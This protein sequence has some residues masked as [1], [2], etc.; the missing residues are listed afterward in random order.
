MEFLRL[1][2]LL[3]IC[4]AS[5]ILVN[6]Q[7]HSEMDP[8]AFVI[9][10]HYQNVKD[11]HSE[12][13]DQYLTTVNE[14]SIT[15]F[16][17]E[18]FDLLD[19]E[20][21]CLELEYVKENS[22]ATYWH[23]SQ[24]FEGVKL[25]LT[26]V[27][28]KIASD[29]RIVSI[30]NGLEDPE[31]LELVY[32]E[33]PTQ[34]AMGEFLEASGWNIVEDKGDQILLDSE[35]SG[36]V[37][38][39]FVGQSG[40]GDE[41]E[42]GIDGNGVIRFARSMSVHF[43]PPEEEASARVFNPDPLTA[44]GQNYGSAGL[45]DSNDENS[46]ELTNALSDVSMLVNYNEFLGVYELE[47]DYIVMMNFDDEFFGPSV[48]VEPY[49]PTEPVF[50]FN[51]SDLHFEE[52]NVF[53]H[54]NKFQDYVIDLGFP[55]LCFHEAPLKV[56][57]RA[58]ISSQVDADQSVYISSQHRLR[59]GTGGIDDGEDA[60]VIIHEYGH[61]LSHCANESNS[62]DERGAL[63]EALGDYLAVSYSRSISE[64]NAY[65]VFTWDGNTDSWS[66]RNL[67]STR[68]YPDDVVESI[69]T[70]S[71]IFS[72]CL[73]Q[74]WDEIDRETMDKLV[75]T[76]IYDWTVGTNMRQAATAL[77]EADELLFGCAN[78]E[79][80]AKYL[81]NRGLYDYVADAGE[82]QEMCLGESVQ[83]GGKLT[84][85]LN[86]KT[87]WTPSTGLDDANSIHP[88]ASPPETTTYTVKVEDFN[89]GE[90][91]EDVVTVKV[92]S[93]PNIC[94][95]EDDLN[96]DE[97]ELVNSEAFFAYGSGMFVRFPEMQIAESINLYGL[98]G[99][100]M[101]QWFPVDD[102]PFMINAND[103]SKGTYI[104]EVRMPEESKTFKL[105]KSR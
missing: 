71:L 38:R 79:V 26:K 84:D 58:A 3:I 48:A 87:T 93:D 47:S 85:L 90:S 17:I 45:L 59:F 20:G 86:G 33:K 99:R 49:T 46:P 30:S 24:V 62:G 75:L 10:D 44:L 52:V 83:I 37:L 65:K 41:Y 5:T 80:M 19:G 7:T 27:R 2:L 81:S 16:L 103:L 4:C 89:R 28:V 63:D 61:A 54:L 29:G 6:G 91:S 50:E 31:K 18:H 82:D 74:M 15:E 35:R 67:N 34:P 98:D 102:F 64:F 72:S 8:S 94:W 100:L 40:G 73:M 97:P 23:F 56:D 1:H 42:F 11:V 53:Y 14:A 36:H 55:S 21:S 95:N 22:V 39:V 77:L 68:I 66:G 43:H 96:S 78:F 76:S 88:M 51:R 101:K 105:M 32:N 60:D 25:Y 70:S 9:E 12:R 57:A 13:I 92:I 69:H 104:L